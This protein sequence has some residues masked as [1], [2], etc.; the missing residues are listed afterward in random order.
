MS[1]SSEA[2][3]DARE[4]TVRLPLAMLGLAQGRLSLYLKNGFG[5]DDAPN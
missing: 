2:R 3:D 4:I 5:R 1:K